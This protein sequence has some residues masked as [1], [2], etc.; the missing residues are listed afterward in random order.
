M[1][2]VIVA[3]IVNYFTAVLLVH[4][5][6]KAKQYRYIEL[7]AGYGK[8]MT[9]SVKMV[10]FINNWGIVVGYTTLIN[11]LISQSLGILTKGGLPSYM[12][13]VKSPFWAIIINV[14]FVL[15]LTL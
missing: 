11:I 4:A 14:V 10:F 8:V 1:A 3:A 2:L 5:G 6:H 12:T 13:D 9:F 15:P 7:G